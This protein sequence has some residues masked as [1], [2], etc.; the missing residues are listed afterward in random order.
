[1]EYINLDLVNDKS[2][3]HIKETI[4]QITKLNDLDSS[5]EGIYDKFEEIS[6]YSKK[7]TKLNETED[8]VKDKSKNI[9]LNI[10]VNNSNSTNLTENTLDI[11]LE[12]NDLKNIIVRII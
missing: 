6:I 12:N 3:T 5:K 9:N 8:Y 2:L 1:M 7:I 4:K 11:E 10:S